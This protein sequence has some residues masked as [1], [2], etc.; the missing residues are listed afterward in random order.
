ML[1]GID[2]TTLERNKVGEC[3]LMDSLASLAPVE[4]GLAPVEHIVLGCIAS[5]GSEAVVF[6]PRPSAREVLTHMT[7]S[8]LFGS[9][10]QHFGTVIELGNPTCSEQQGQCLLQHGHILSV[11]QE[12]VSIVIFNKSHH[13]GGIGIQVVIDKVVVDTIQSC[14]PLIGLLRSCLIDTVIKAEVHHSLEVAVQPSHRTVFLPSSS[15]GR[16]SDPCFAY[17]IKVGVLFI[18]FSHPGSHGPSIGIGI[19]IHANTVDANGFNPPFAVL[20][21]VAHHV[22]IL[23]VKVG[24]SGYEPSVHCLTL[25]SFGGIR[26][27]HRSQFVRSL[28]V[29]TVLHIVQTIGCTQPLW[30]V[31]P[32]FRWHILHPRMFK[33]TMIEYHVH[34]QLDATCMTIN[35]QLTVFIIGAKSGIYP[36]VVRCGIAMVSTIAITVGRVILQYRRKPQSGHSQ[37]GEV[38]Q[39]LA[40]SFDVT[41]M[42]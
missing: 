33:S 10:H 31:E 37:F 9:V 7:V 22:G 28:Q 15:I 3:T 32:I 19:G 11:T 38:V 17:H 40:Q 26:V 18:Q 5:L 41:S 1:T 13:A 4:E 36:I 6:V 12:A 24:H 27:K 14:P 35:S 16:F 30:L 25:I 39:M 29:G 8:N 34:H 2:V 23:L 20:N 42:A 21:Q